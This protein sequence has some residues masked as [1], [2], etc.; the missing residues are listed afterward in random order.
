MSAHDV[1]RRRAS[2]WRPLA[3]Y[4]TLLC[5]AV[6]AATAVAV[7]EARAAKSEKKPAAGKPHIDSRELQAREAFA[8]GRYRE[9]L[10]L[11]AKLYAE[12]LHPTFLRNIGRCHQHMGNPEEAILSFR[13]YLRKASD[14]SANERQE[15][16]GFI[17]EMEALKDKQKQEQARQAS[18]AAPLPPAG[19]QPAGTGAGEPKPKP[20]GADFQFNNNPQ[21]QPAP[22]PVYKR[23]W[24]W[25]V[26]GVTCVVVAAAVVG[27]LWAGGVF[28]SNNCRT[29]YVCQ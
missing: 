23:G 14:L 2:G 22:T 17:R 26:T 10:D 5:F 6:T 7:P 25:A 13:D 27:G 4:L 12:K 20:A 11:Y 24:F 8:A 28:K 16:E 19:G 29:G 21:P 18:T 9:S 1:S 15:V 3:V